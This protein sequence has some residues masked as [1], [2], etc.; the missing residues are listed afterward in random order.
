MELK[1]EA[2]LQA[3]SFQTE[4]VWQRTSRCLCRPAFGGARHPKFDYLKQSFQLHSA[5]QHPKKIVNIESDL[6][7]SLDQ[8]LD[9]TVHTFV[10]GFAK[11]G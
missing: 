4:N 1:E 8:P 10:M 5:I 7:S 11:S 2:S 9:G 3:K 6:S